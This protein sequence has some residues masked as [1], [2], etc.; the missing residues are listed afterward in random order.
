MMQGFLLNLA[1]A[2][3]RLAASLRWL[4]GVPGLAVERLEAVD[5]RALAAAEGWR[6]WKRVARLRFWVANARRIQPA[7]AGC[8]L[9][10]AAAWRRVAALDAAAGAVFED[11]VAGDAA[12]LGAALKAIAGRAR[13]ERAEV[14]LLEGSPAAEH[15][16][17][18]GEPMDGGFYLVP[19]GPGAS[20]AAAYVL[21][22]AA[23][24]RLLAANTPVSALADAWGRWAACGVKVWWVRP[25]PCHAR[26]APS[27]IGWVLPRRARWRWYAA[28][29]RVRHAVGA[30]ADRMLVRRAW[31]RK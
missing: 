15:A 11:D 29:W 28:L 19:A 12:A 8:A 5:G 4:G 7:E 17:E 22:R 2:R 20:C 23:A 18:T 14:W 9:S 10:H 21:S 27:Q 16:L 24:R 3:E 31:R 6:F 30:A 1:G 25:F 26:G 13:A